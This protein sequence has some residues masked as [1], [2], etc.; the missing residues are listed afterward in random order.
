MISSYCLIRNA[1]TMMANLSVYVITY[2]VLSAK[3]GRTRET[4]VNS[5]G[6]CRTP[7]I[8]R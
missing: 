4:A 1:F 6:E 5:T 2:I 7:D 8:G 3:T